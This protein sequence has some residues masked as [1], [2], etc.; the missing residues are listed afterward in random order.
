MGSSKLNYYKNLFED[1]KTSERILNDREIDEL[2][3]L[4]D[5]EITR[6][7]VG[8]EEV[9][10]ALEQMNDSLDP[11]YLESDGE[12]TGH[13]EFSTNTIRTAIVALQTYQPWI[14]VGT[15][16]PNRSFLGE[17]SNGEIVIIKEHF[18]G[19]NPFNILK[20]PGFVF[21][22]AD[23]RSVPDKNWNCLYLKRWKELQKGE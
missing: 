5:E 17:L 14:G 12:W 1:M 6:Q 4:F 11:Q 8:S 13:N 9:R 2:Y 21:V 19:E 18:E 22:L 10:E 16:F 23:G 7:L 3:N 15:S 20:N